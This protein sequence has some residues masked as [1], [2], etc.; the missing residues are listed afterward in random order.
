MDTYLYF[1]V[2]EADCGWFVVI[3]IEELEIYI[4]EVYH[5]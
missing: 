3:L 4:S 2:E 5:Y 1:F